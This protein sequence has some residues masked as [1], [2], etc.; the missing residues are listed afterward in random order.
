MKVGDLQHP[1]DSH[2]V[3]FVGSSFLVI[4]GDS[5]MGDQSENCSFEP[6]L[7]SAV[8]LRCVHQPPNLYKYY[9]YPELFLVDHDFGKD[10]NKCW[11]LLWQLFSLVKT[12]VQISFVEKVAFFSITQQRSHFIAYNCIDFRLVQDTVGYYS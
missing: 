9:N 6:G 11:E 2:G 7:G 8:Q 1:R 10:I 5:D 12:K 4:G 3:I